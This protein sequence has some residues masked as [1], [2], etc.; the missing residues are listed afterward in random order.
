MVAPAKLIEMIA[1]T[2][3]LLSGM[4]GFEMPRKPAA[5]SAHEEAA[6]S[7][8]KSPE[9]HADRT[10]T[11]RLRSPKA[12]K[13]EVILEGP[14][15]P[16]PCEKGDDGVWSFTSKPL[17]PDLYGYTFVVDGVA[18]LDPMNTQIKPNLIWVGNMV[19]VPGEKAEDWEVQDVPHGAV[20]QRFY[21]SEIIG[22]QR[23]YFV[24]TP[25]GYDPAGSVK[26]PVLYLLHGFSDTAV[27]WTAV[28]QA[29]VI[30]DNLI[31]QG[32]AKPMVVVM[33]L[34]YGVPYFGRDGRLQFGLALDNFG[35]FRQ[36]LLEEVMPQ[37]EKQYRVSTKREDRA[38]AG[39]S[40]GGAESLFT[41]LNNLDTFGAIG[42]FS[43]G[44][45]GQNQVDRVFP[46]LDPKKANALRV[47]YV[48]CGTEDSLIGFHRGFS[49]WLT[50]KGVK[51]E[52]VE[53]SGGHWWMLWRRNLAT[54]ASK[55]FR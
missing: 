14:L 13:V 8:I 15:P 32:R 44:G 30:L 19:L 51:H 35:K 17:A 26:Y 54:F 36:A 5:I 20:Q 48:I 22:D 50:D 9:V 40:M 46:N 39:L 4:I 24:Y 47:F 2:L 38:I 21:K 11:F 27:G 31:E 45:L 52:A 53:T 3:A 42:A 37:V 6:Q 55:I 18:T 7:R 12:E 1:C 41:G 16:Q 43:S 23:D 25:P 34:G 29:H 28:G 49:K 10:V 33:P